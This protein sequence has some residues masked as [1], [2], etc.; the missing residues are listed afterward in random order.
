MSYWDTSALVKLYLVEPDSALFESFAVA[1]PIVTGTIAQHELHTVFRR[2]EAEGAIAAGGAAA[3]YQRLTTDV[4]R[5]MLR[6]HSDSQA[7]EQEFTIVLERVFSRTPPLLLRTNDALHLAA[8]LAAGE[9]EFVTADV[10]QREAAEFLG[11]K[12]R[13]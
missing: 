4:A 2:R 8:A 12:L 7:L 3:L 5:G 10:R 9:S 13:P 1:S 6:V 11:F